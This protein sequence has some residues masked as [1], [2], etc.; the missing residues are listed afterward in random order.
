YKMPRRS[1]TNNTANPVMDTTATSTTDN[2]P[3]PSTNTQGAI[4]DNASSGESRVNAQETQ[5]KQMERSL[6]FQHGSHFF[7]FHID[8]RSYK[9]IILNNRTLSFFYQFNGLSR[10]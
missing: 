6:L 10:N 9:I 5:G 2:P 4:G 8:L 3:T 1:N 7:D